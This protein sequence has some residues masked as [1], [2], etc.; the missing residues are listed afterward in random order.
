M[1][2]AR[3]LIPYDGGT[4]TTTL[5]DI[6]HIIEHAINH[7]PRTLQATIGPSELGNPCDH[8]LA[9]KLA[10][11]EKNANGSWL[12]FVGTATHDHI[13][14][15]F[16]LHE[17]Y[18]DTRRFI[19]EHKVTVG[20]L[21]GKPITGTCDLYDAATGTVVDFKIVGKTTLD[22]ARRHGPTP[23]YRTQ[24]NLYG[25]G[26]ANAGA[27]VHHVAIYYLPRNA[28]TLA[29]AVPWAEAHNP[30]LA[31]AALERASRLHAN[32][33]AMASVST[34]ARDQWITSLPRD[35]DCWDCNRYPDR[36]AT[37]SP[38]ADLIA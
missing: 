18:D 25:L 7:Q 26:W 21:A 12:P 19:S 6:R 14:A 30:D 10:G 33:T 35:P 36:P 3:P 22:K 23:V 24:V 13:A 5:D 4:P 31:H 1:P 27:P 9:A 37:P 16:A 28:T 38:L 11:W 32:L 29:A 15:I 34:E 20:H 2:D 8:C 17:L